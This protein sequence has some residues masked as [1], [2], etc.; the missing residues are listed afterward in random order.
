MPNMLTTP[1]GP[2]AG[3]A[4]VDVEYGVIM[5]GDPLPDGSTADRRTVVLTLTHGTLIV[6][7]ITLDSASTETLYRS[8]EWC[9]AFV[10]EA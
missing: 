10:C 9:H 2:I 4:P 6:A 1:N 5:T 8:A 3:D 7:Q